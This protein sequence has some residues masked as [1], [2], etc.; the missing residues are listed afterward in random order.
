MVVDLTPQVGWSSSLP[1]VAEIA[2]DGRVTGRQPGQAYLRASFDGVTGSNRLT[3]SPAELVSLR[4]IPGWVARPVGVAVDFQAIGTFSDQSSRDVTANVVWTSSAPT[5]SVSNASGSKGQARGTAVGEGNV[6]VSSGGVRAN[7]HLKVT[8][9][10]LTEILV[11]PGN[12]SRPRGLTQQFSATGR[13]TDG[14]LVS[15]TQDV[16]WQSTDPDVVFVSNTTRGLGTTIGVGSARVSATLGGVTG[17]TGFDTTEAELVGLSL[18]PVTS[19]LPA[20]YSRRLQAIGHYTDGADRVVNELVT[21]SSEDETLALASNV[22]GEEGR[23]TGL[24]AGTVQVTARHDSLSASAGLT[25][26]SAT[27]QTVV[28]TAPSS[29]LP[30]GYSIRL[31]ASGRFSDQSQLDLTDQC[32][33]SSSDDSLAVVSAG[34]VTGG[35]P[36]SVTLTATLGAVA[37]NQPVTI[38]S[39][40]L[41]SLSLAPGHKAL[42]VGASIALIAVGQFD[43]G[44]VLSLTDQVA[45]TNSN[46]SALRLDQGLARGVAPGSSTVTAR[47]GGLQAT[48]EVSVHLPQPVSLRVEPANSTVELGKRPVFQVWAQF[49][50]GSSSRVSEQAAWEVS[51]PSV[52][53]LAGGR[54][55]TLQTGNVTITARVNGLAG[56]TEL[57]VS[58]PGP[59]VDFQAGWVYPGYDRF[60]TAD[61]DQD[62]ILDALVS[63][64]GELAVLPTLR[65]RRWDGIKSTAFAQDGARILS[66]DLDGDGLADAVVGGPASLIVALGGGDGTFPTR[67]PLALPADAVDFDQGDFNGDSIPDLVVA[68][69]SV[70]LALGRGDGTFCPPLSLGVPAQSLGVADFNGDGKADLAVGNSLTV[71]LL[72][73]SGDGTFQ[74]GSD[75]TSGTRAITDLEVGDMNNDGRPDVV[76][77]SAVLLVGANLS[78]AASQ[79]LSTGGGTL[80][81]GDLDADGNLDVVSE[82]ST[83]AFVYRGRGNGKTFSGAAGPKLFW[84]ATGGSKMALGDVNGDGLLDL[85][86]RTAVYPGLGNGQFRQPTPGPGVFGT[87]FTPCQTP[88]LNRDG[89]KDMVGFGQATWGNLFAV[90]S[91]GDGTFAK[92]DLLDGNVVSDSALL[93]SDRDGSIDLL[94][95]LTTSSYKRW[96][97]LPGGAFGPA[98]TL[99]LQLSSHLR[100]GDVNEDG[101]DDI[102]NAG[103]G[104]GVGI[105]LGN[106]DGTFRAQTYSSTTTSGSD[107]LLA[108]LN[109]DGHLDVLLST[110]PNR[111]ELKLGNGDGTFQSGLVTTMPE[112]GLVTLHSMVA[113]QADADPELEVAGARYSTTRRP[114]LYEYQAGVGMVETYLESNVYAQTV[115]AADVNGD[116]RAD[117]VVCTGTVSPYWVA[118]LIGQGDG[119]FQSP[120]GF[121]GV[122]G[123]ATALDATDDGKP[124]IASEVFLRNLSR[125]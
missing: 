113:I 100:V 41:A 89:R 52:A 10:I 30:V 75:I 55:T 51:A 117:L 43:Q 12:A 29:K 2:P 66:A 45:W 71:R 27:L 5:I 67:L 108:D 44:T 28:L 31:Q 47:L 74:S 64:S 103:F 22:A 33:W 20:G 32:T 18:A 101:I 77:S 34:R 94:T 82:G 23:V 96:P 26:T 122:T 38:T 1:A 97:G 21:W 88:D 25:V 63:R 99:S 124:D 17:S 19:L 104:S 106:G 7:G 13:Y 119:T 110:Y 59:E 35:A 68:C 69:G 56:S 115:S 107:L 109:V 46:E 86:G 81:L 85:A 48:T 57:T 91:R 70:H 42:G 79:T 61:V 102:I 54:A 72:L 3:I 11:E 37:A 50:D 39:E 78:L 36:G 120:L 76:I 105:L 49:A 125:P 83:Q 93:D 90:L 60:T 92:Q 53:T 8:P 62:G 4:V 114:V 98:Q 58:S 84:A 14:G 95:A 6:W 15:L 40:S 73:G 24:M 116:G 16:T 87:Q 112:T 65:D 118:V 123:S 121:T 9:A 80:V 111:L